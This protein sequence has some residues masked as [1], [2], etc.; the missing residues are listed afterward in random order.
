MTGGSASLGLLCTCYC[1]ANEG[2]TSE[3][4][5][6]AVLQVLI[7]E[8]GCMKGTDT[9]ARVSEPIKSISRRLSSVE[10]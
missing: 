4:V 1:R 7:P 5:N 9:P 2:N 8:E 10:F 3:G 6:S